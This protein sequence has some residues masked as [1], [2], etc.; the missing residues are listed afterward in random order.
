MGGKSTSYHNISNSVNDIGRRLASNRSAQGKSANDLSETLNALRANVAEIKNA[1][2]RDY[3]ETLK[4]INGLIQQTHEEAVG[5]A[6]ALSRLFEKVT[7]FSY[8]DEVVQA[9]KL[10]EIQ[11][12]LVKLETTTFARVS[13]YGI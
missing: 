4:T 2:S 3:T 6:L 7:E 5:R 11:D 1:S 12:A 8:E 10:K 9:Q 13:S